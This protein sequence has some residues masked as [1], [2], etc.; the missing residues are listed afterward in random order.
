MLRVNEIFYSLQGEGF[1]TG[2][3]MT[4]IRLSG[5]NLRCPFCD[6]DHSAFSLM[7]AHDIVEKILSWPARHAVITGGEPSLQDLEDLVE[8][9][10]TEGYTVHIETNGT[11]LLPETIDWI[12]CSPKK[13]GE[14]VLGRIDELKVVYEGED[15]EKFINLFPQAKH[16]YL[17]P[18]SGSNIPQTVS[19]V[20]SHPRWN[21]SLQTHRLINIP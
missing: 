9:L 3:P 18:M 8:L 5:C 14:V 2:T 12:T 6:T 19:Y 7:T 10:H 16:F 21:L 15:V 13:G 11:N 4:F 20:L 1:W 17:Q